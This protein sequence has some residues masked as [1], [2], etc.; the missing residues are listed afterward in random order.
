MM[1]HTHTH[2]KQPAATAIATTEAAAPAPDSLAV[3]LDAMRG[4]PHI[5][6]EVVAACDLIAKRLK[7]IEDL[8]N[9]KP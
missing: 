1:T 5:A 8:A 9:I 3:A 2:P 4:H 6:P 7:V